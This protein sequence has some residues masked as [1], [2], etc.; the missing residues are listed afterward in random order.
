MYGIRLISDAASL[1]R[2]RGPWRQG[3]GRCPRPRW[4]VAVRGFESRCARRLEDCS[5]L[6][7]CVVNS[8]VPCVLLFTTHI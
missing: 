3:Q 6:V 7:A 2:G 8:V 4:A 1:A 5:L